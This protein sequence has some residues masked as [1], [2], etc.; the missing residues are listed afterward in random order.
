MHSHNP[1]ETGGLFCMGSI[2]GDDENVPSSVIPNPNTVGVDSCNSFIIPTLR[3]STPCGTVTNMR[4]FCII[5]KSNISKKLQKKRRSEVTT[6]APVWSI[7][8]WL[9]PSCWNT[10]HEIL[11]WPVDG[12]AHCVILINA[13]TSDNFGFLVM[14]M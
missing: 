3:V 1:L 2:L 4:R 10:S 12:N 14:E 6:P 11:F 5:F 13:L 8:R 9:S 7:I